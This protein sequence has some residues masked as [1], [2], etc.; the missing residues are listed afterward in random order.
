MFLQ[1]LSNMLKDKI[2][3]H[4][5]YSLKTL[6]VLKRDPTSL[7][8]TTTPSPAY[9]YN[10]RSL[11]SKAAAPDLQKGTGSLAK[12]CRCC[13]CSAHAAPSGAATTNI[14]GNKQT[15]TLWQRLGLLD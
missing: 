2:H 12:T 8:M 11:V 7:A 4:S 13:C 1:R 15:I 5:L 9:T 6:E 14:E 3:A 10:L